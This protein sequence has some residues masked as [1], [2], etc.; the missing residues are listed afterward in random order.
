MHHVLV[1]LGL[2]QDP[3]LVPQLVNEL[4]DGP[5]DRSAGALRWLED[6]EDLQARGNVHSE[7]LETFR[8]RR[9]W[10]G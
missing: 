9:D 5:E 8:G 10:P 4:L 1:A 3:R 6:L 2:G 7:V